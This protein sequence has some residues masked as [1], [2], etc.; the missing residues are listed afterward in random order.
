M[1]LVVLLMSLMMLLA[2]C[3]SGESSLGSP[4]RAVRWETIAECP[5]VVTIAVDP[6]GPLPPVSDIFAHRG[7]RVRTKHSSSFVL[8]CLVLSVSHSHPLCNTF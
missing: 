1:M 6:D 3:S 5:A 4:S 8:S 2:D 7:P